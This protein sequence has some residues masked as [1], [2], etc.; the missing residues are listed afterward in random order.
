MWLY[1]WNKNVWIHFT[2]WDCDWFSK[3]F[4]Y[5]H[6]TRQCRI[7]TRFRDSSQNPKMVEVRRGL[8]RS[9][10]PIPLLKEGCLELVGMVC[11]QMAF[12]CLQG[13]KLHI[14]PLQPVSVL[15]HPHS[16][17]L[18]HPDRVTSVSV[19]AHW[20]WYCHWKDPGSVHTLC[21]LRYLYT[22]KR[23]PLSLL[24]SVVN[25]PSPFF[26]LFV[27]LHWTLSSMFM[28]LSYKGGQELETPL[29]LWLSRGL[30]LLYKV[31]PTCW[32]YFI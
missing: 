14:L 18:W 29:Q 8:W 22:L 15:S 24:F 3:V 26:F 10:S 25:S 21:I 5:I 17:K 7:M 11:V 2:K 32:Q 4:V 12:E 23:L 6:V 9:L 30:S 31:L 16:K 20:L 13:W 28:P 27:A 19:C 1:K